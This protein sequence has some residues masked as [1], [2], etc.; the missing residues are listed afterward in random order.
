[1]ATVASESDVRARAQ[2]E[3]T[4]AVST[5]LVETCMEDAHTLL[6]AQLRA[7]AF[8]AP[9]EDAVVLGES[10]LAC[11]L[12]LRSLA[13]RAALERR[14]VKVGGQSLERGRAFDEL[15]RSAAD[16]E[17]RAWEA[18]APYVSAE[19]QQDAAQP[20]PTVPVLGA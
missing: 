1:M 8:D 4:A 16:F 13:S 9:V 7:D 17:A 5:T 2:A 6:L 3:D 18:L 20:T 14:S 10:L 19:P 12:L 15:L 11:S